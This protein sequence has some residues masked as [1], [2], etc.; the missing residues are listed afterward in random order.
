MPQP[1][2]DGQ[3]NQ[4]ATAAEPSPFLTALQEQLGLTMQST[5]APVDTIVIEHIEKPTEN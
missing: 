1:A 2:R 4:G 5:T 3:I